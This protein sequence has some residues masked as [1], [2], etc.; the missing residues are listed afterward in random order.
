MM[1]IMP[2]PPT[3]REIMATESS[4]LVIM[5]VVEERALVSLPA[6]KARIRQ[7]S[8]ARAQSLAK[9]ALACRNAVE[10]HRLPFP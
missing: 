8:L 6:V 1:F 7:V 5:V 4:R 3:T 2:T 10:V 9:Q